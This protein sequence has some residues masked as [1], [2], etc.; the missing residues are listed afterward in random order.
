M[1]LPPGKHAIG[2][3]WV[4]KLKRNSDGTIA[5]HKAR[6]VAKGYLQREGVDF[7]DTFSPVAKQPTVRI[8]L[9]MA[10]HFN[11][12][13]KQLDISNAF[14]H[15]KLEEEVYML[16]P[17]GF[18]DSTFPSH[19]CRLNKALYGLKQ[20]PRA[21]YST[22]SA[23]LLQHGFINSRCDSSL[24][25]YKHASVLT[26]LL[27]YVD[28]IVLTG[29]STHHIDQ[30]TNQMHSVF[31]MKELGSLSYFLG[32]SVQPF[33]Q[34]LFLSQSKYAQ[35]ILLKAGLLDCKP[36]PSP[37]VTKATS[38]S[39]FTTPFTNPAL[40]RSIVGALQYLTITRP[41][42]A[43]SVNQACQ[44]MHS[45]SVGAFAGVKRLLRFIKGTIDHGLV[46]Q[47]SSFVLEALIGLVM[48]LI[49]SLPLVIVFSLEIT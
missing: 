2:C 33:A 18:E 3:K 32:I 16:Q 19:V 26:I 21:W 24:F 22:F 31:S 41:D 38:A 30:L 40:F 36:S 49:A 7:Q 25:V 13:L 23:F 37:A 9:C 46:F 48:L 17:P 35:D 12:P 4:F 15:G 42:I 1:S 45:P 29:N 47:P 44:H 27:V 6:L 10:L 14:L 34:G 39:D 43:F 5:R 20:A 28:D 11:W 8:L